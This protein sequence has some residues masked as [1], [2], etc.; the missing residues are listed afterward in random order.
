MARISVPEL[1]TRGDSAGITALGL[2]AVIA[3]AWFPYR[4]LIIT[5]GIVT[6]LGAAS[7]IADLR[8]GRAWHQQDVMI[9]RL[10]AAA[11]RIPPDVVLAD[12]ETGELLTVERERGWLTLAVTDPPVAG[13]QPVVTRYPLGQWAAPNPPPLYRH[14]AALDDIPPARWRWRQKSWLAYYNRQAGALEVGP[15]E[16]AGLMEQLGR[17]AAP[18]LR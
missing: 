9:R 7:L 5:G 14:L 15:D 2:A 12:A 10:W 1:G 6:V 3:W 11:K 18:D 16:L 17:S 4:A 13:G 8:R